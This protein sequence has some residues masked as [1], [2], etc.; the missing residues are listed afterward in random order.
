MNPPSLDVDLEDE[1]TREH[2]W[3]P[4]HWRELFVQVLLHVSSAFFFNSL[5]SEQRHIQ[6]HGTRLSLLLLIEACLNKIQLLHYL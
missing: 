2:I 1:H 3:I 6:G 5:S 4:H